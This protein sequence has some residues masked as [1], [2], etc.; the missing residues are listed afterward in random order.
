[1]S[2]ISVISI[3]FV[4]LV[5]SCSSSADGDEVSSSEPSIAATEET[6][7]TE[8]TDTTDAAAGPTTSSVTATSE[9]VPEPVDYFAT[10]P[11]GQVLPAGEECAQLVRAVPENVPE[12]ATY[13]NTTGVTVSGQTYLSRQLEAEHLEERIDGDFTGTTDEVIQWAACKWGFDEDLVRAQ[14]Y[15]E[16]RWFAGWLGDCGETSQPETGGDGGCSSTGLLQVRAAQLPSVFHPGTWPYAWESTA[17]NLDYSLAVLRACFEGL[18]P[19]LVDFAPNGDQYGPGDHLGCI[20]RWF[21]GEWRD[22]GALDYLQIVDE[23]L[24]GRFWEST[25]V[26]CPDWQETFY[27]SGLDR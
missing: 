17:F 15:T 23:N 2:R 8:S 7:A 25:Y 4:L 6:V 26:G 10:L 19:W 1:M 16:S 24:Q 22:Q 21:S 20:G 9:P 14:V 11:P 13:N 18:E 3:A 12:N 5:S 27:C